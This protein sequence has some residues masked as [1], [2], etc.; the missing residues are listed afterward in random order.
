[1][2][3]DEMIDVDILLERLKITNAE[4]EIKDRAIRWT[5][6]IAENL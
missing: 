4:K 5:E 3:L 6:R 1:L 2:I